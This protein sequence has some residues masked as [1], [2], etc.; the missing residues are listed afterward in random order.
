MDAEVQ[1]EN[2]G[3][4]ARADNTLRYLKEKTNVLG[5]PVHHR[6]FYGKKTQLDYEEA[7]YL[8]FL[9]HSSSVGETELSWLLKHLEE[10]RWVECDNFVIPRSCTLTV[11]GN[12]RLDELEKTLI[13]SREGFVAMWFD[14]SMDNV[15]EKGLSLRSALQG[16]NQYG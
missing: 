12:T 5:E 1:W 2:L 13:P 4:A 16:T 15:W 11:E 9:A 7:T 10:K 3:A 8:E 14:P 6:T